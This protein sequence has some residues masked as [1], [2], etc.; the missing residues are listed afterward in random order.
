M[1]EC[2][3]FFYQKTAKKFSNKLE[4]NKTKVERLFV[5]VANNWFDRTH[6]RK[7]SAFSC[8]LYLYLSVD[9]LV[10]ASIFIVISVLE[11]VHRLCSLT[12]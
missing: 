6:C 4:T 5:K 12:S 3:G 9:G 1:S 8:Y 7:R 11:P 10:D 2:K